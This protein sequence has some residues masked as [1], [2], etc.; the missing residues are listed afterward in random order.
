MFVFMKNVIVM[1]NNNVLTKTLT[2]YLSGGK[3]RSLKLRYKQKKFIY[4][5]KTK[6]SMSIYRIFKNLISKNK[7][8]Y[9][10]NVPIIK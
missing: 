6:N 3:V 7:F 10:Q 5:R 1:V 4:H 9:N 8:E 2:F